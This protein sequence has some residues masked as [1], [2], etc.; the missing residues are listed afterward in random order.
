[1]KILHLLLTFILVFGISAAAQKNSGQDNDTKT[2]KQDSGKAPERAE[3]AA[4]V[5]RE[6]AAA[7]D[8]GIPNEVLGKSKC[9]IVIPGVKNVGLV[10]GGRYGRGYAT[11]RARNGWSAPAPVFMGGGSYGA[12]IGAEG[13]DLVLLV[14]DDKGVQKLLSSKFE[15]GVDAS[16]AAGPVGRSASAGTDWKLN[17]EIL[18]YSR[19][20]GLFA[21]IDISGA[22]VR[23]DDS[24]T[25]ELYGRMIPFKDILSGNVPTP[26]AAMTFVREVEKDFVEARAGR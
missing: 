24:T 8:K 18:S 14:V 6:I 22:K 21:G 20:K 16:A 13:V 25:K 26:Q 17:S 11:C 3:A 23:Q 2:D 5:L 15:I 1:M 4:R 19:A 7:P 12:Q 10:F 9:V